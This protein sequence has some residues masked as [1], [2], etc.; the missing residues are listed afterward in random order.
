M[1]HGADIRMKTPRR[2]KT[3]KPT[4]HTTPRSAS[5]PNPSDKLGKARRSHER[6]LALAHAALTAGDRIE[7]E[8]MYQHAE[9]YFRLMRE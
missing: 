9:H 5:T 1:D 4:T 7:A 8:N 2:D 3:S 6:Y